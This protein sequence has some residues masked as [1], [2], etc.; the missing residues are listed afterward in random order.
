MFTVNEYAMYN[1]K[2][3]PDMETNAEEA[4]EAR[5]EGREKKMGRKRGTKIR[6]EN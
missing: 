4:N 1:K 6:R 5:Y 2:D 3:L